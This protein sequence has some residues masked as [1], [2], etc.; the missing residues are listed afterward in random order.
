MKTCDHRLL[1]QVLKLCVTHCHHNRGHCPKQSRTSCLNV[2]MPE[3]A[4]LGDGSM[5]EV[6]RHQSV[7]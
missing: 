2:T 3:E 6:A 1:Q 5:G 4:V 7:L